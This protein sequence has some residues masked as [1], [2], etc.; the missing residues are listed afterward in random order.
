MAR[1]L[2]SRARPLVTVLALLLGACQPTLEGALP[3][4]R[5]VQA[6]RVV[7]AEGPAPAGGVARVAYPSQPLGGLPVDDLDVAG[8]DLMALWGLP[9]YRF[10]AA[11]LPRPALVDTARVSPDGTRVELRLR[12]GS[13]SDGEPVSGHDVRATVEA[14]RAGADSAARLAWLEEVEVDDADASRIVLHLTQPTRRWP[15]L[16]AHTGVLAAH[17]LEDTDLADLGAPPPVVGGPYVPVDV[18]PGL[19]WD[20]EAHPDG[21]LG[22]PGLDGVEVLIVPAFDTALGMLGQGE[23]DA[24]IGHLA[25]RPQLRVEGLDDGGFP[26]GP[27]TLTV[28]APHGGTEVALRFTDDGALGDRPDL[29]RAVRDAADVAHLVE[30]LDLGVTAGERAPARPAQDGRDP[31]PAADVDAAMMVSSEQEALV[32]TGRLL[33]AQVRGHDGRLRIEDEPTPLDVRRAGA[34]DAALVVRRHPADRDLRPYLPEADHDRVRVAERALTT[35]D[36][37]VLEAWEHLAD[38]AREVPLYRARVTHVWHERLEG[39][40]PSAWP[41]AGLSSAHRW[42]LRDGG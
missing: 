9:L 2:V 16:L 39:V 22:P 27:E 34:L 23:L 29:R 19:R 17:V 20:F 41:G 33:E 10:D 6:P 18:Q 38:V 15:Q 3:P 7:T 13:W 26:V 14:V 32:A 30:G 12:R 37:P 11:G 35:T 5:D 1:G 40:E 21:P 42:R 25:I 36:Q 8:G 28:A 24:I 4:A 31:Q